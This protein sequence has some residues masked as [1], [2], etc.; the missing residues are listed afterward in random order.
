MKIIIN[1]DNVIVD[2]PVLSYED[3][4]RLAKTSGYPSV[5]FTAP[6]RGDIPQRSGSLHSGSK[7]LELEDGIMITCVHTGNA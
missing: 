3:I 1:G 2:A 5:A 6:P 7:P 4:V